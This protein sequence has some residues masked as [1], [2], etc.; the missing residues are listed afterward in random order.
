MGVVTSLVGLRA[1][2]EVPRGRNERDGQKEA[3][4]GGVGNCFVPRKTRHFAEHGLRV[5]LWI[6]DKGR[7]TSK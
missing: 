2:R 5:A 6:T 7:H 3:D 1:A 4:S